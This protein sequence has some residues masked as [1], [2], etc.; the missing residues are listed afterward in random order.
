VCGMR[1]PSKPIGF[2]P[3]W[4]MVPDD[5]PSLLTLCRCNHM[6]CHIVNHMYHAVRKNAEQAGL[7]TV[8]AKAAAQAT[9]NEAG[10]VWDVESQ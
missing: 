10:R 9:I 7:D 4:L 1:S 3:I 5:A 6:G 8:A 2:E